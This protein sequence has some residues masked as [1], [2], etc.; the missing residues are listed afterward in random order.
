MTALHVASIFPTYIIKRMTDL[1]QRVVLHRLHQL[2]KHILA[3]PCSNLQLLEAIGRQRI[4]GF[5]KRLHI[6]NL[7]PLFFL[8]RTN[9]LDL[10]S[11]LTTM[12]LRQEGVDAD[13]RQTAVVLFL[14][15][16]HRF[17]LNLAALVHGVHGA[18]YAAAF[19]DG[20]DI[21]ALLDAQAVQSIAA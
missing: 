9:Q 16:I 15:V 17:F 2:L 21:A 4:A 5:A 12:I 13:Q 20:D 7:L 6:L 11:N 1:S 18:E 10:G 8:R 3:F 19:A 14:L